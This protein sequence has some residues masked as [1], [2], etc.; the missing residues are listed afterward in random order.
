MLTL[1]IKDNSAEP[2]FEDEIFIISSTF[3][4]SFFGVQ[5]GKAFGIALKDKAQVTGG[6]ILIFLG[7]KILVEHLG[8]LTI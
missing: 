5:L 2:F 6:L 3:I 7:I 8:L 4:I 1:V